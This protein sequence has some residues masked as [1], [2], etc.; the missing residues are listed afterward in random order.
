MVHHTAFLK[1]ASMS[2]N[3]IFKIMA[4]KTVLGKTLKIGLSSWVTKAFL[5][6][7]E[8]LA[9]HVYKQPNLDACK[10]QYCS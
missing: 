4:L 9:Y 2:R 8:G 5:S 10:N 7:A 1:I 6:E 3:T